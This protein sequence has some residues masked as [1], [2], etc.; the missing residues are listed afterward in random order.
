MVIACFSIIKMFFITAQFQVKVAWS[1]WLWR[2][3]SPFRSPFCSPS[4]ILHDWLTK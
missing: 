2:I 3:C 4:T 1:D